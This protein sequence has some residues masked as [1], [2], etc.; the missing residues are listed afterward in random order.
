MLTEFAKILR[1]ALLP[2]CRHSTSACAFETC[3]PSFILFLLYIC[4]FVDIYLK[5]VPTP[6]F[7]SRL[8]LNSFK[9]IPCSSRAKF[10]VCFIIIMRISVRIFIYK[11][12]FDIRCKTR[13]QSVRFI[14]DR[15]LLINI[16]LLARHDLQGELHSTPLFPPPSP[17]LSRPTYSYLTPF[18][19]SL[20][21]CV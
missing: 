10:L 7:S 12:L 15:I 1:P 3:P 6:Q 16:I 21:L 11:L 19:F 18:F 14:R 13:R 8:F 17:S 5:L 2:K 20:F 9:R 4:I